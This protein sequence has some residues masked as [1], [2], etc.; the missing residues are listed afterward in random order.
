MPDNVRIHRAQQ[1]LWKTK[2][3]TNGLHVQNVT[4]SMTSGGHTSVQTAAV[5]TDYTAFASQECKTLTISNQTGTTLAV[6]QGGAG[7][8][9]LLP[10]GTI[11]KFDGL[12][13]AN[14][15]SVKRND[16]SNTQVTAT[17]R[18]EN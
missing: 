14:Q 7:V 5:G 2:E 11:F 16:D 8:G 1:G 18:W 4:A 17:A 9:L 10:T 6:R 15:L 3:V 13:N 12:S